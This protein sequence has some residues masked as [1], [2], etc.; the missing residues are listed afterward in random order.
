[1]QE[2]IDLAFR[3][4]FGRR[5]RADEIEAGGRLAKDHGLETVCR[6][7]LNANEFLFID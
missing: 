5:P 1:M 3:L 2:Q 7:L 6:T 4:A